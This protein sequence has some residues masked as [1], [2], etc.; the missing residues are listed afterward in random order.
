MHENRA[1]V[2]ERGADAEDRDVEARVLEPAGAVGVHEANSAAT[3][4]HLNRKVVR[5]EEVR[6]GVGVGAERLVGYV[7]LE[8][9]EALGV[10]AGADDLVGNPGVNLHERRTANHGGGVVRPNGSD[11]GHGNR[12]SAAREGADRLDGDIGCDG[13]R[14][15]LE[16]LYDRN[17]DR[18]RSW[19]TLELLQ[20]WNVLGSR[21]RGS[22]DK[23]LQD[24]NVLGNRDSGD[25]FGCLRYI[26]RASIE[27]NLLTLN[28]M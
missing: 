5:V 21:G 14:G 8:D 27:L 15:A 4:N 19:T 9:I 24:W 25:C 20:D 23:L 7:G 28:V 12:G 26:G 17:V 18:H 22:T 6:V 11:G 16:R 10:A 13:N 1:E 3:T 2:V